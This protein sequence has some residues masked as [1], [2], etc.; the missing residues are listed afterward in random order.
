MGTKTGLFTKLFESQHRPYATKSYIPGKE[1]GLILLK[2]AG[3]YS[4]S[5]F[6]Y[7]L[8]KSS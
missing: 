2:T 8:K 5:I 1:E 3:L 7:N 6:E 4:Y